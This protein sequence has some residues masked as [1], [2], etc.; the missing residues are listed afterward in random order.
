M[1]SNIVTVFARSSKEPILNEQTRFFKLST[2]I[3]TNFRSTHAIEFC[4]DV[5]NAL[6]ATMF[7]LTLPPFRSIT[8]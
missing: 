7:D 4:V 6:F 1:S 5:V 8:E 3:R 2:L